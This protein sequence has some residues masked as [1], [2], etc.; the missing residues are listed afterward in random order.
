MPHLRLEGQGVSETCAT[1]GKVFATLEAWQQHS[2]LRLPSADVLAPPAPGPPLRPSGPLA[3]EV[4][5]YLRPG[6]LGDA[7]P[8]PR[9]G[10]LGPPQ[11]CA[12]S[13]VVLCMQRWRW[14]VEARCQRCG[15][16]RR[17]VG[18]W[19]WRRDAE[20]VVERVM[21]ALDA[22][23]ERVSVAMTEPPD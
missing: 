22:E 15:M 3:F 17:T 7:S 11:P 23:R 21:A 10:G 4:V 13:W 8:Q 14:T 18:A 16:V 1:C 2:H 6:Y 9:P 19:W 20:Q 12:H 5:G